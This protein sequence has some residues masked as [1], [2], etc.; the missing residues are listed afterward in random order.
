MFSEI[1]SESSD[2]LKTMFVNLNY[3]DFF[4]IGFY[5]YFIKTPDIVDKY[6]NTK[7]CVSLNDG[8]YYMINPAV[9]VYKLS[10]IEIFQDGKN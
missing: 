6:G 10:K 3:G 5:K 1:K 4:R 2:S 7:N 9:I 8:N